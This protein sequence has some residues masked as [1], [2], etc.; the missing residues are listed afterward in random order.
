MSVQNAV[1]RLMPSRSWII[2]STTAV[3]RGASDIHVEPTAGGYEVRLRIDG[4]LETLSKHDIIVG[5]S[6]VTRLMVMAHLLTYR[7]DIPQ[8]GRLTT[9]VAASPDGTPNLHDW[10]SCRQR[11]ACG[12]RSVPNG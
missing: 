11:T 6:I 10:P 3:R 5:R 9:T 8:E 7:L 1:A 4:L 2:S 12:P